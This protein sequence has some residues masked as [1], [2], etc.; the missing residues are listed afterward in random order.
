[1]GKG[2]LPAEN[3]FFKLMQDCLLMQE[4][5]FL[6]IKSKI[7]PTKNPDKI[8]TLNRQCLIYLNQQQNA[9]RILHLNCM[10]IFEIKLK[11]MKKI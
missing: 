10:E 2:K 3:D 4:K 6:M 7:F 1:M 8:S 5:N 9:L 11:I